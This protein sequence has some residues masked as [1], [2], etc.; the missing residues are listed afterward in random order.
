MKCYP[1]FKFLLFCQAVTEM[2]QTRNA[3]LVFKKRA[4]AFPEF[5]GWISEKIAPS[6]NSLAVLYISDGVCFI[7]E[8][9]QNFVDA[10][11]LI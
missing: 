4:S 2:V 1:N 11:F 9:R 10:L 3:L 5:S 8:S 7:T 6:K